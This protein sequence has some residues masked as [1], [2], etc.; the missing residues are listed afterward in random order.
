MGAS[1]FIGLALAVALLGLPA[2]RSAAQVTVNLNKHGIS[3]STY[4]PQRFGDWR[5]EYVYWRP[6][7]VYYVNGVYYQE[8]VPRARPVTVY[9]YRN[10][11]F[12]PPPDREFVVY[13]RSH[14]R[15]KALG[16]RPRKP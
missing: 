16:H 2:E 5:T 6:V 8:V 11:Y 3:L 9:Y 10:T 13:Q 14:G 15:G 1:K 4:S 12:L 7:T